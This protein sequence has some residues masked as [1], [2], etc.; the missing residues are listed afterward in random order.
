MMAQS[1]ARFA[2][3]YHTCFKRHGSLY[4]VATVQISVCCFVVNMYFCMGDH[5]PLISE[6]FKGAHP[7]ISQKTRVQG[8]PPLDLSEIKSS[9]VA[10]LGPLRN[11]GFKSSRVGTLGPL[12]NQGFKGGH[13]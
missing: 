1:F 6:R 8:W 2:F 11:Q 3:K 5:Q 4:V 10:T 12:R 7:W 9:R 13:P